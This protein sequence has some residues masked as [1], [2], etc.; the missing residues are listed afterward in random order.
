MVKDHTGVDELT[1]RVEALGTSLYN[2]IELEM[3]TPY[4]VQ[5]LVDRFGCSC[6][7]PGSPDH[8]YSDSRRSRNDGTT[9]LKYFEPQKLGRLPKRQQ[10]ELQRWRS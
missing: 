1:A 9:S 6:L 7:I 8:C 4:E 10:R 3:L 2:L 5:L